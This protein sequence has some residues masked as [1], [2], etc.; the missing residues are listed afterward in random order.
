MG[1]I[2]RDETGW[3]VYNKNGDYTGTHDI[4]ES[5][6]KKTNIENPFDGIF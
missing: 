4:P 6:P 5:F 3:V 1:T 2:Y